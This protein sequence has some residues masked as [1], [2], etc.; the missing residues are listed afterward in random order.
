MPEIS[1]SFSP[2]VTNIVIPQTHHFIERKQDHN[3]QYCGQHISDT[4]SSYYQTQPTTYNQ[5]QHYCEN[6]RTQQAHSNN[7]YDREKVGKHGNI[8]S[9]IPASEK[10]NPLFHWEIIIRK[11]RKTQLV[12]LRLP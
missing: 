12:L 11:E 8:H 2:I 6:R 7:Y 4:D 1:T 10:N 3:W 5:R 9:G